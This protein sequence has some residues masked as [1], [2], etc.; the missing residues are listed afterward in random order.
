MMFMVHPTLTS[1]EIELTCKVISE[2]VQ[3]ASLA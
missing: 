2:V 1:Q 3:Q